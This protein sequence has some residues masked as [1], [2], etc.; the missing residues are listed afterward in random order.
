LWMPLNC[1]ETLWNHNSKSETNLLIVS[2]LS[3]FPL[4]VDL[5]CITVTGWWNE[6][7]DGVFVLVKLNTI[8]HHKSYIASLRNLLCSIRFGL[9]VNIINIKSACF[10][11]FTNSIIWIIDSHYW[12]LFD[13]AVLN[14]CHLLALSSVQNWC[15]AEH[16]FPVV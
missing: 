4:F 5:H 7:A 2:N 15:V 10:N 16:E 6:W 9:I 13:S 3:C 1:S 11:T 14:L 12:L 8:S